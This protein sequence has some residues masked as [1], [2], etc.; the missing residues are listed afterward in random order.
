MEYLRGLVAY[1]LIGAF[2]GGLGGAWITLGDPVITLGLAAA[3]AVIAPGFYI[4]Q[5]YGEIASAVFSA[6]V[7][8]GALGAFFL[9]QILGWGLLLSAG[10]GAVG[11]A[12]LIA[13]IAWAFKSPH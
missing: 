6:F 2:V 12:A 11:F 4:L 13:L 5:P 8:G 10:I 1:S 7:L 3:M 9:P